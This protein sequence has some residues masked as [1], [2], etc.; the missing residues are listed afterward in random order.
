MQPEDELAYLR[1]RVAELENNNK[2]TQSDLAFIYG[3]PPVLEKLLRM[4]LSN[5]RITN[6]MIEEQL[7]LKTLPKVTVFR[8]RRF[9]KPHGIDI[10]SKRHLGYWLT[11]EDKQVL[12]AGERN[13]RSN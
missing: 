3:L 9:L 11:P 10:Q 5:Q 12:E 7:R 1:T 8:L 4:L 2:N 13:P 6:E